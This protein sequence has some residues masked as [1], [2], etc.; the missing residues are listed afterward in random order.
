MKEETFI[1]T[2][3]GWNFEDDMDVKSI[4]LPS[5]MPEQFDASELPETVVRSR[6]VEALIQQNDTSLT[7]VNRF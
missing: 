7:N 1:G 2:Q 5:E 3:E 4:P 6:A